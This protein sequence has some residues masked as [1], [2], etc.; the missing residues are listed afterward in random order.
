MLPLL[1]AL[2]LVLIISCHDTHLIEP[3]DNTFSA[4][5]LELNK[6]YGTCSPGLVEDVFPDWVWHNEAG[7]LLEY[8]S[9]ALPSCSK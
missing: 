9:S 1:G 6:I 5:D 2:K 8:N 7:E 4:R 3:L